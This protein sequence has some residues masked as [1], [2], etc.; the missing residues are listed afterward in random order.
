MPDFQ[1][2]TPEVEK[3]TG[4]KI[5]QLHFNHCEVAHGLHELDLVLIAEQ[6]RYLS[7]QPWE[8]DSTTEAVIWSC[9]KLP[10]QSV[11]N[12][13]EAGFIAA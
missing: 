8:A 9:G 5:M 1:G 10:I 13:R 7:N 6:C 3:Q 12:S 4:I 11:A 2:G